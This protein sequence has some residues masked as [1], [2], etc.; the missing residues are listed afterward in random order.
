MR[1]KLVIDI[2]TKNTFAD[3]GGKENLKDLDVSLVCAY[4]YELGD[5]LMFREN[6]LQELGPLLRDAGLVVGFSITR[7]DLPVLEKYFSFNLSA[8]PS[9]DLLDE[10][11]RACG[12]RV[13]LDILAKTNLGVG[14]TNHSLDAIKFYKQGDWESLERY[15]RQ[16][17]LITRDLYELAKRQGHLLVPDRWTGMNHRVN[18]NLQDAVK[19]TNTLF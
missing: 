9:L 7:F 17:V 8:V 5:F 4:S 14:K 18:L 16:D 3:V 11:E 1:D 10:I 19:E 15:C 6:K 2:E 12:R 13:S